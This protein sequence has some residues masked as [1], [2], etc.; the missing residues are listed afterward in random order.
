MAFEAVKDAIIDLYKYVVLPN[1]PPF[2]FRVLELDPRSKGEKI[3]GRM[4]I[5]DWDNVPEYE[6]ISYAWGDP[7]DTDLVYLDGKAVNVTKN[8]K[9][10]LE[11]F[12]YDDKTRFL[13]ADAVW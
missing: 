13:W 6:A 3:Q 1:P 12:R 10:A 5:V 7:K 9:V 4:H 8:L 2:A 11:H